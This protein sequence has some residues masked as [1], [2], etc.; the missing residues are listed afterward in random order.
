MDRRPVLRREAR[1]V[2]DWLEAHA[3]D[4]PPIRVV[5][6]E[7]EI[8]E[9]VD[10]EWSIKLIAVLEDPPEPHRGWSDEALFAMIDAADV[11][12][13]TLDNAMMVYLTPVKRSSQAA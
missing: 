3:D 11:Y 9:D 7:S 4:F 10:D 13:H 8:I 2:A 5:R 12:A 6:V 1:Q